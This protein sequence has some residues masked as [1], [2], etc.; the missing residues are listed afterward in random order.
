VKIVTIANVSSEVAL[1]IAARYRYVELRLDL[2][3]LTLPEIISIIKV[4]D[5]TILTALQEVN[6]PPYLHPKIIVDI[7]I[8]QVGIFAT[9][10]NVRTQLSFHN[11]DKSIPIASMLDTLQTQCYANNI[12]D[13]LASFTYI[14]LATPIDT[15][16]E[17]SELFSLFA[18]EYL[19]RLV[20]VPLGESYS[21]ARLRSMDLGSPYMFFYYDKA[22]VAGQLWVEDNPSPTSL[23]KLG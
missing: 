17:L 14:K 8:E 11:W 3:S 1:D 5:C 22:V 19:G 18:S 6:I 9:L 21:S 16:V 15:E 13:G 4:A 7:P 12:A 2:L 10:P 23:L 20:L